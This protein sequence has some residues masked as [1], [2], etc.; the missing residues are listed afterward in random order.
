MNYAM[1]HSSEPHYDGD[2]VGHAGG[3]SFFVVYCSTYGIEERPSRQAA[4]C[5]PSARFSASRLSGYCRWSWCSRNCAHAGPESQAI[6][7][8]LCA[9]LLRI[10]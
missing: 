1:V 9:A 6:A 3:Y 2:G 5:S 8:R 4:R 7:S 10:A